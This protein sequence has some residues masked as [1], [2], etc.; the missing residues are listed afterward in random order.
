M[1]AGEHPYGRAAAP[2]AN[3]PRPNPPA[4]TGHG[5]QG[6]GEILERIL[7]KGLVIAGD[8]QVNL[9]DIELITIKVRLLL[10]S[11]D[12]AQQMGIDWWRE[13]PFLSSEAREAQ[14]AEL[15]QENRVLR[16]RLDRLEAALGDQLPE[17]EDE[18]LQSATRPPIQRG[19]LRR[20]GHPEVLER[21]PDDP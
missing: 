16:A 17:I 6:L 19:G 7:D 12:T 4:P 20:A 2:R 13:D 9:L 18:D 1:S 11:A 21:L 3:V 8:V 15:E 10:A 5:S 14:D